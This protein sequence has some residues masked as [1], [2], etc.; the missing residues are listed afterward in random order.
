MFGQ[1]SLQKSIWLNLSGGGGATKS[2][3]ARKELN[4]FPPCPLGASHLRCFRLRCPVAVG[5]KKN[6][7][8]LHWLSLHGNSSQRKGKKG[9][10]GQLGAQSLETPPTERLVNLPVGAS[11][12]GNRASP[13]W[14]QPLATFGCFGPVFGP[15]T[16]H[17]G[18]ALGLG[19][20]RPGGRF[21]S[22]VQRPWN[23]RE[24]CLG[25]TI[26]SGAA[27]KKKENGCH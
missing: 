6:E 22:V 16:S 19:P 1:K 5:E 11:E 4:Q 9:T 7:G 14:R 18:L 13:F 24:P 21:F 26:F 20:E 8:A 17:L 10:T 27:T 3:E 12:R 23:K 15:R 25:K 2:H